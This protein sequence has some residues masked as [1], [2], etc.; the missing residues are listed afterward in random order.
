MLDL[1]AT[2]FLPFR[3]SSLEVPCS[4]FKNGVISEE[5]ILICTLL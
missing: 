1:A 2:V 3:F 5:K 4:K